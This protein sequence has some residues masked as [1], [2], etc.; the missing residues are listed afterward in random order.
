M[1]FVAPPAQHRAGIVACSHL[2]EAYCA[3]RQI[4]GSIDGLDVHTIR[5]TRQSN[6]A[7][8]IAP[9]ANQDRPAS[10]TILTP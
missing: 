10:Y 6:A 2:G 7:Y 9:P 1:S 5:K 3:V 8:V 4:S